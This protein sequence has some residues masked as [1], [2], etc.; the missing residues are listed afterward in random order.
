MKIARLT[1][2]GIRPKAHRHPN[3]DRV[4]KMHDARQWKPT[5]SEPLQALEA[6]LREISRGA[7]IL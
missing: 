6:R 4:E 2:G 1:R 7:K 3:S 5:D